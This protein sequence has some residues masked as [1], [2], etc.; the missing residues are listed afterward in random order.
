M[1]W[2]G[3]CVGMDVEDVLVAVLAKGAREHPAAVSSGDP[4]CEVG[5]RAVHIVLRDDLAVPDEFELCDWHIGSKPG[6]VLELRA[7]WE[8]HS[9]AWLGFSDAQADQRPIRGE[10]APRLEPGEKRFAAERSLR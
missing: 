4:A 10:R 5:G 6:V 1:D 7:C 9:I 3:G 8:L 2:A